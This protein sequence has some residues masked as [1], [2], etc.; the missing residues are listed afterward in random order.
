[1]K[2]SQYNVKVNR[3]GMYCK[4][5]FEDGMV[6]VSK[7]YS[8]DSCTRYPN[9]NLEGSTT[10][11]YCKDLAADGMVDIR[12]KGCLHGFCTKRPN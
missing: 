2:R 4:Q 9:F 5:P 11:A 6:V 1:M 8:H 12:S 10:A 7:R 3:T